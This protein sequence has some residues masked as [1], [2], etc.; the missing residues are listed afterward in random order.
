MQPSRPS[1]LPPTIPTTGYANPRPSIVCAVRGMHARPR[2]R[3][4]ACVALRRLLSELLMNCLHHSPNCEGS[5]LVIQMI[6]VLCSHLGV[7]PKRQ[8]VDKSTV[9]PLEYCRGAIHCTLVDSRSL[10]L[11][12]IHCTPTALI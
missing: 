8:I 4:F 7:R 10:S 3:L 9:A 12:A 6:Y 1:V 2:S 11:G 5:S